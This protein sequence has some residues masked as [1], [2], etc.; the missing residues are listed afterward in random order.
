[1]LVATAHKFLDGGEKPSTMPSGGSALKCP[2]R[3]RSLVW[4]HWNGDLLIARCFVPWCGAPLCAI[5]A[6]WHCAHRVAA[7]HGGPLEVANLLPVCASCNLGMGTRTLDEWC[8]IAVRAED[9]CGSPLPP[10]AGPCARFNHARDGCGNR[11]CPL[12]HRCCACGGAHGRSR[13]CDGRHPH[14]ASSSCACEDA[15]TEQ[16]GASER[17]PSGSCLESA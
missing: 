4:R 10:G 15:P 1:M 7:V 17:P 3:L 9:A 11:R 16:P 5:E 14:P 8:A 12:A 6:S 2:K 13:A